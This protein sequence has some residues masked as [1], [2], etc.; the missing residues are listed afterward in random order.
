LKYWV[1]EIASKN[2]IPWGGK[3]DFDYQ[4][5]SNQQYM[6]PVK[7][8]MVDRSVLSDDSPLKILNQRYDQFDEMHSPISGC[9][10]TED[11]VVG[12]NSHLLFIFDFSRNRVFFYD[13]PETMPIRRVWYAN[14]RLY[15]SFV[16]ATSSKDTIHKALWSYQFTRLL[17]SKISPEDFIRVEWKKSN[18]SLAAA[19]DKGLI[20]A[21]GFKKY[22][23]HR[24][25]E[26]FFNTNL[27]NLCKIIED[28][29][30][31][32]YWIATESNGLIWSK[33]PF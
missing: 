20:V 10:F 3:G 15:F 1:D 30:G 21:N 27:N 24:S 32:G 14:K 23:V 6:M 28:S 8:P 18:R 29:S 19:P 9:L 26:L 5:I 2:N 7:A 17:N 12:F 4:L 11:E 22:V 33:D 25:S 31:K 16:D 13:L